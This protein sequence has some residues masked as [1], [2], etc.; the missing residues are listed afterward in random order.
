M[1][2]KHVIIYKIF[3]MYY[4]GVLL[5]YIYEKSQPPRTTFTI[6]KDKGTTKE[7]F[8][9]IYRMKDNRMKV[10]HLP[11]KRY[12][13]KDQCTTQPYKGYRIKDQCTTQPYKGYRMKDQ[14]TTKPYKYLP[15]I[16]F[17]T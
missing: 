15:I 9:Y 14:C 4:E 8:S 1:L 12:R 11:Y 7:S 13:I 16:I 2:Q 5:W 3:T 17:T 10:V 6:Y